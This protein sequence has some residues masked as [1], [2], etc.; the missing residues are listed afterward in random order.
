M[1]HTYHLLT[2]PEANAVTS[3]GHFVNAFSIDETFHAIKSLCYKGTSQNRWIRL[4]FEI[5]H[6]KSRWFQTAA[7]ELRLGMAIGMCE[8]DFVS[9]F[10]PNR[11]IGSIFTG[12]WSFARTARGRCFATQPIGIVQWPKVSRSIIQGG[13]G[14]YIYIY[15]YIYF[16]RC[17]FIFLHNS[18]QDLLNWSLI[19]PFLL[20]EAGFGA[21][22]MAALFFLFWEIGHARHVRHARH[23]RHEPS[24]PWG[25][26]SGPEE[27][28]GLEMSKTLIRSQVRAAIQARW[29][30]KILPYRWFLSQFL[31]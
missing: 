13:V 22:G 12:F 31:S 8:S 29:K 28:Q 6:Q 30:G 26:K 19:G 1:K 14:T 10:E 4:K 7:R 15:I 2:F 3:L 25:S 18:W 9:K 23:A 21:G 16:S 27:V 11:S 5:W 17:F 24:G 20:K